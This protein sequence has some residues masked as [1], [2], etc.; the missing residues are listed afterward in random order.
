MRTYA[1][2]GWCTSGVVHLIA[3]A[4]FAWVPPTGKMAEA[5]TQQ[6]GVLVQVAFVTDDAVPEYADYSVHVPAIGDD[7]H[8]Q[9]VQQAIVPQHA[10]RHCQPHGELPPVPQPDTPATLAEVS[11][12]APV[13][14]PPAVRP[15]NPADIPEAALAAAKRSAL[16]SGASKRLSESSAQVVVPPWEPSASHTPGAAVDQLPRKLQTNRAPPYPPDAFARRQEGQVLLEVHVNQRGLVDEI[17][18]SRSSGVASL[19]QAALETVRGWRF[20]PARSAGKPVATVVTV[21][22]RFVIRGTR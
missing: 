14:V 12:F 10:A 13:L 9:C 2:V 21:P 17:S 11:Q 4:V 16:R 20:D 7:R 1:I 8:D 5:W 18:V 3:V 6:G 19:D 22:I 15:R